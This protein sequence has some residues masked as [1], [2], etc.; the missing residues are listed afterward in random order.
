MAEKKDGKI[1]VK[2]TNVVVSMKQAVL[3]TIPAFADTK[4]S[5]RFSKVMNNKIMAENY[6]CKRMKIKS[7]HSSK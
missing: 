7:Y 5:Q 4:Q 2:Q 1:L 6:F 3:R